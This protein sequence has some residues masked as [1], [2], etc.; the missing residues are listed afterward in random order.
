VPVPGRLLL[1]VRMNGFDAIC[2]RHVQ[3]HAGS[4]LV[5][6]RPRGGGLRALR[7]T[8]PQRLTVV[9]VLHG[10]AGEELEEWSTSKLTR[11]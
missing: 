7:A 10:V 5:R 8:Q 6:C 4:Q 2:E 11:R 1:T 3:V 9:A